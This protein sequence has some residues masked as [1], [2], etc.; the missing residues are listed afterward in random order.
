ML[1]FVILQMLTLAVVT[2]QY[3]GLQLTQH[4]LCCI[5]VTWWGGPGMIEA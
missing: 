4:N 1:K 3:E 5:I 2:S